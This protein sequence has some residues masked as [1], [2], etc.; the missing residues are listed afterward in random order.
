[1]INN[2]ALVSIS[3]DFF[4]TR[5]LYDISIKRVV[6]D[7]NYETATFVSNGLNTKLAFFGTPYVVGQCILDEDALA[8][9]SAEGFQKSRRFNDVFEGPISRL[10]KELQLI[11]EPL[12]SV[13]LFQGNR[14]AHLY[15]M[16]INLTL[17]MQDIIKDYLSSDFSKVSDL[18]RR[19]N[20]LQML[21]ENLFGEELS[22]AELKSKYRD[23]V[24]IAI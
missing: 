18:T 15:L 24:G 16:E 7:F 17:A 1:M 20:I 23:A 22:M 14:D 5:R 4:L 10:N 11:N 8:N 12:G 2:I 6:D 13:E 21:R 19:N 3:C 9:I